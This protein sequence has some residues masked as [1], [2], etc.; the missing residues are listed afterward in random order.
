VARA[1][2]GDWG[3]YY[4]TAEARRHLE[5]GDPLKRYLDRHAQR[6]RC[7]FAG[8]CLLLLGLVTAFCVVLLR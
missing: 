6:E 7:F 2:T 3:K 8:T 1:T 5:G 4:E